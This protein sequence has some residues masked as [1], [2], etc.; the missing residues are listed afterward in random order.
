MM[1][2]LCIERIKG[3][4]AYMSHPV[5]YLYKTKKKLKTSTCYEFLYE[6]LLNNS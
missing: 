3:I 2:L 4:Y 6:R 1:L 5:Y